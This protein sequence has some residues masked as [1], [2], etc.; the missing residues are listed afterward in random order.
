VGRV[1]LYL[2]N[3]QE[4][5]MKDESLTSSGKRHRTPLNDELKNAV[6]LRLRFLRARGSYTG[7]SPSSH[8]SPIK[9]E[10]AKFGR[11]NK[12]KGE[13]VQIILEERASSNRLSLSFSKRKGESGHN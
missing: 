12:I 8:P 4:I 13:I 3:N 7:F 2:E 9:G 1:I 11:R 5:R 10:G 6:I